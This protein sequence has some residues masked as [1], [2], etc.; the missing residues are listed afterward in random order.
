[1]ARNGQ[2]KGDAVARNR[3]ARHDY[4]IE[5]TLEA[6]I[7]LS[8]TEVKSLRQ[9][10]ATITEAFASDKEDELYLFNAHVPEYG[11]G[12]RFNHEPKRPRETPGKPERRSRQRAILGR[13]AGRRYV[14]RGRYPARLGAPGASAVEDRRRKLGPG[15]AGFRCAPG[16]ANRPAGGRIHRAGAGQH[17][18]YPG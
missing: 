8:G 5:E 17:P 14:D 16:A 7:V 15:E 12:S 6:G 3:K 9:G 18:D 2:A 13:E 4:L 10:R 1:M 11:A